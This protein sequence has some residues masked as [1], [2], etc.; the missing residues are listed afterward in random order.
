[1]TGAGNYLCD[2]SPPFVMSG[3]QKN[4]LPADRS[5]FGRDEFPADIFPKPQ[6]FGRNTRHS[7][8]LLNTLNNATSCRTMTSD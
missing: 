2:D 1:M 8:N 7:R 6:D 3:H 5:L 4:I